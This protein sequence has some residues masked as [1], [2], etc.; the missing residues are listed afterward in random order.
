MKHTLYSPKGLIKFCS[1][2]REHTT[3]IFNFDKGKYYC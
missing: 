1:S 3:N 2:L